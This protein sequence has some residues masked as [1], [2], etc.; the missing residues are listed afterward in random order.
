MTQVG[1]L[2]KHV[3]TVRTERTEYVPLLRGVTYILALLVAGSGALLAFVDQNSPVPTRT[4][5]VAFGLVIAAVLIVMVHQ[6]ISRITV[7]SVILL[8]LAFIARVTLVRTTWENT[9]CET[10]VPC[11]PSP[12][13]HLGLWFGLAGAFLLAA[14]ITGVVGL[15]RS[16]KRSGAAALAPEAAG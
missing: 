9:G 11:D 13:D 14:L 3:E 1:R 10:G 12:N 5:Y 4:A 6:G 7:A 16:L 8:A 2:N 15:V